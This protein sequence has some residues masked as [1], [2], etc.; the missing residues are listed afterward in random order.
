MPAF[1]TI[2]TTNVL[3]PT[4]VTGAPTA[5]GT[6]YSTPVIVGY[7]SFRYAPNFIINQGGLNTTNSATFY[8][9][10]GDSPNPTNET[11]IATNTFALT[12]AASATVIPSTITV[13]IYGTVETVVTNNTL[14]WHQVIT[15]TP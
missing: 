2:T 3:N 14:V 12:N 11:C 10:V 15:T 4:T 8:T 5:P 6:N 9:L 1:A 13:P 7:V